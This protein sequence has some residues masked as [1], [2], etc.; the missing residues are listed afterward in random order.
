MPTPA[1]GLARRTPRRRPLENPEYYQYEID[2]EEVAEVWR[3]GT[4]IGSWLLDLTAEALFASPQLDQFAG[5]VSD[6]GEGRWTVDRRDRRWG[7]GAGPDVRA[8]LAFQLARPRRLR[9]PGAVGD[10]QGVR[11]PRREEGMTG[12][13]IE[14]LPDGEA[15]ARQAA[16]HIA[17]R[18]RKPSPTTAGSRSR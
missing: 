3:R 4:V 16:T 18:A 13:R 12:P 6:S 17:Q 7:P 8:V 11:G 14:V 1:S 2:I 5:R 15:A 9:R 10:A